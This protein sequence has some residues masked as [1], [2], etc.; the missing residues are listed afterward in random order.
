LRAAPNA[1][2]GTVSRVCCQQA[3]VRVQEGHG[4]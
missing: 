1:A 4:V 2:V 3:W